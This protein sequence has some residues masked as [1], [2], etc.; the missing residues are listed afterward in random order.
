VIFLL[1]S[2]EFSQN[3][4]YVSGRVFVDGGMQ[5][6]KGIQDQLSRLMFSNGVLQPDQIPGSVQVHLMDGD[7]PEVQLVETDAAGNAE[8]GQSEPDIRQTVFGGIDQY[9]APGGTFS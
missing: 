7:D 6:D 8:T 4:R 2:S 5:P 1:Q 3:R 9:P